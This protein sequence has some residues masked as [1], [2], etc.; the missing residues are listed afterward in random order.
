MAGNGA[1]WGFAGR[2]L[3]FFDAV[4][5]GQPIPLPPVSV[6]ALGARQWL[7]FDAWPPPEAR[8]LELPLSTGSFDVDPADPPPSLGGRGLLV[9]MP[10]TGYGVRDQRPLRARGDVA[11]LLDLAVEEP[12]LLL[13]P[14]KARLRVAAEGGDVRQWVVTLC[15]E[16]TDGSLENLTEGVANAPVEATEVEV[17]LGDVGVLLQ[18]GE[19][20]VALAAG[21][22]WPRWQLPAEQ[23]SQHVLAGS[24]LELSRCAIDL[25]QP[26]A[27]NN[28]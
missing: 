5:N 17:P 25:G 16:R 1:A 13:G 3:D 2:S 6:Y 8:P 21:A 10:G 22:S 19:R 28:S 4:A 20:L 9:L 12:L 14:V 7:E 11:T 26:A 24:T 15:V 18:P 27:R 23:G